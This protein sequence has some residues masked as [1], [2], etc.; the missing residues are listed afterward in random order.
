VLVVSL[1][2]PQPREIL[3]LVQTAGEGSERSFL[4]IFKCRMQ[5]HLLRFWKTEI[6][7][8]LYPNRLSSIHYHG[9][10]PHWKGNYTVKMS[11]RLSVVALLLASISAPATLSAKCQGAPGPVVQHPAPMPPDGNPW[12]HMIAGRL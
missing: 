7:K 3:E 1:F 5:R 10:I 4:Q 8:V 11:S 9:V 12:P 6:T 2:T